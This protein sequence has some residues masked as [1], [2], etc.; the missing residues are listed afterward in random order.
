[1]TLRLYFVRETDA[2][3]LYERKNGSQRWIPKSVC[4]RVVKFPVGARPVHEVEIEDWWLEKN[5]WPEVEQKEI[6]D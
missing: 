3:R 6:N 1:M 2:A 4:P 5:P